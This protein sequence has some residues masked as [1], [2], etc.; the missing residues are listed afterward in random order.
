[1]AVG[2]GGTFH[3][4][5]GRAAAM[6]AGNPVAKGFLRATHHYQPSCSGFERAAPLPSRKYPLVQ[7]VAALSAANATPPADQASWHIPA[8]AHGRLAP[9]GALTFTLAL[10]VI[11]SILVG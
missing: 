1:M 8:Q 6:D 9:K 5:A 7:R 10:T 3:M 2:C 4:A 11:A